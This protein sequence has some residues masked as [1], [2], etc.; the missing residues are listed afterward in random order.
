MVRSVFSLLAG[1]A[2]NSIS[3]KGMTSPGHASHASQATRSACISKLEWDTAIR[4]RGSGPH[5]RSLQQSFKI[6]KGQ[7]LFSLKSAFSRQP[8]T[9]MH[10]LK[11]HSK[12]SPAKKAS[13]PNR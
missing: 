8:Q 6:V 9:T 4:V 1:L 3:V 11:T 10:H 12:P 5:S 7:R 13:S 2:Y